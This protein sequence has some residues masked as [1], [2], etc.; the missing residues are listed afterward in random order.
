MAFSH[1]KFLVVS[2]F[3]GAF[4]T[5]GLKPEAGA[6]VIVRTYWALETTATLRLLG[7]T[8]GAGAPTGGEGRGISRPHAHNFLKIEMQTQPNKQSLLACS[9]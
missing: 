8:L 6:A 5:N 3:W 9:S 7:G 4:G 2:H 1:T